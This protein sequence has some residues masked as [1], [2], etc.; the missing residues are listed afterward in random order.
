MS[1]FYEYMYVSVCVCL[2]KR[3]NVSDVSIAI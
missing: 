3:G 2:E 1:V